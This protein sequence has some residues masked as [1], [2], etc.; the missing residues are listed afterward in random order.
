MKN[1]E[2]REA[3]SK[4]GVKQWELAEKC[5]FSASWFTVKMRK[6]FSEEEK[7]KMLSLIKQMYEE[8]HNNKH[9]V[10]VALEDLD[11]NIANELRRVN[12]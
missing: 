3:L 1:I 5:G 8:K 9:F 11:E 2:I 6:E 10:T 4:S 12:K 7:N